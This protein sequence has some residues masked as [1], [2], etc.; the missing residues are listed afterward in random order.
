MICEYDWKECPIAVVSYVWSEIVT[1]VVDGIIGEVQLWRVRL[2][3]IKLEDSLFI[4]NYTTLQILAVIVFCSLLFHVC[5]KMRFTENRL[6]RNFSTDELVKFD[7][8]IQDLELK[9]NIL[10]YKMQYGNWP[11]PHEIP[12]PSLNELRNIKL[13]LSNTS[14]KN[15]WTKHHLH[16]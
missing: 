11:M 9:I 16:G 8:K 15:M 7:F 10:T 3:R 4:N 6:E 12:T 2:C 5:Y 13:T 1:D 14:R